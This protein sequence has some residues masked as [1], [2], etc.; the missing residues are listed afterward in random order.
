[1]LLGDAPAVDVACVIHG[2]WTDAAAFGN[3][4]LAQAGIPAVALESPQVR[5]IVAA[6]TALFAEGERV[7][8]AIMRFTADLES[9][10]WY[11][12]AIA[13]D[14]RRRFSPRRS[15]IRVVDLLCAARFGLERP[16]R[17]LRDVPF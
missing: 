7:G 4:V 9:R 8:E 12:R 6:D 15:A 5:A 13:A 10:D 16:A 1:M 14:S 3:V 17:A 11:G 2:G